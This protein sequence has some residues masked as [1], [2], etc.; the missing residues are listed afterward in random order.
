VRNI[1]FTNFECNSNLDGVVDGNFSVTTSGQGA[2]VIMDIGKMVGDLTIDS[3]QN[4]TVKSYVANAADVNIT[5]EIDIESG[6]HA[7]GGGNN[8]LG[9]Y[10]TDCNAAAANTGTIVGDVSFINSSTTAGDVSMYF[11]EVDGN[12]TAGSTK[13][14]VFGSAAG[15]EITGDFTITSSGST[16]ADTSGTPAA[17]GVRFNAN[18]DVGGTISVDIDGLFNGANFNAT[19]TRTGDMSIDAG[20]GITLPTFTSLGASLDAAAAATTYTTT[21]T[22]DGDIVASAVTAIAHD[23]TITTTA[24]DI[25]LS[26]LTSAVGVIDVQS[27]TGNV[28]TRCLSTHDG[29]SLT[30]GGTLIMVEVLVSSTGDLTLNGD[31][32]KMI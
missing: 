15:P 25:N 21:L 29:S 26:S 10:V 7:N 14:I 9:V 2:G 27:S 11:K 3:A 31:L 5:G 6:K 28:D 22:S 32:V 12:V 24:G 1:R 16:P 20:L 23:A 4:V 19:S 17:N 8:I 13:S 18:T 30:V